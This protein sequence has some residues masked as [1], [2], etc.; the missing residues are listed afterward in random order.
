MPKRLSLEEE[1]ALI[2]TLAKEPVTDQT[3]PQLRAALD[4]GNSVLAARAAKAASRLGLQMLLPDLAAAFQSFLSK[5]AKA[6]K[7]CLAKIALAEALD[8]LGCDNPVLFLRGARHVQREPVYGG[9]VDTAAPLRAI[10]AAGFVRTGRRQQILLEL[11]TLLADPEP[12]PRRAAA[13]NL[14]LALGGETAEM[15]LRLKALLGDKDAEVMGHC[16][17]GLLSLGA[18]GA[19]EFVCGFLDHPDPE[20]V[21]AA[22]IALAQSQHREQAVPILIQHFEK[23]IDQEVQEAILPP[24][25]ISNVPAAFDFLL[26]LLAKQHREIAVLAVR[27]LALFRATEE[28]RQQVHDAVAARLDRALTD[29]YE[30]G[31]R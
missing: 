25:A 5:P 16:F 12:V 24:L 27:A 13:Q 9:E 15:L 14:G 20:V 29:E 2:S 26:T 19:L 4:R 11:T 1:L 17:S 7:G 31:L 10:C 30:A 6:D 22:A 28:Q 18:A 8:A 3:A 23:T 21:N